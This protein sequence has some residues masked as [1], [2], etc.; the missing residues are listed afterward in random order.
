MPYFLHVGASSSRSCSSSRFSSAAG[1]LVRCVY[2]SVMYFML[3]SR[4][5]MWKRSCDSLPIM[6]AMYSW[7]RHIDIGVPS[8]YGE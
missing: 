2:M 6:N 4:L 5:S 1:I 7:I 3:Y 8:R